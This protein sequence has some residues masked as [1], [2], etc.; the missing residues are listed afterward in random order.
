MLVKNSQVG[1]VLSCVKTLSDGLVKIG[2]KVVVGTCEG[3]GVD[4]MLEKHD[5]KIID[6]STKS[7][8][9]IIG[10][11]CKIAKI[12][13]ENNI[14]IIHAQNRVPAI[15]ASVYC[16]FHSRVKYI[17]SNHLVPISS[18][19]FHRLITRSGE[20]AVAESVVGKRYLLDTFKIPEN[21]LK[22]VNLGSDL[23]KFKKTSKEQQVNLKKRL[24]LDDNKKVILLYG[25]LEPVKGHLFL[26]EAIA[27]LQRERQQELC[28]I[29][30]GENE[31]YKREINVLAQK[32]GLEGILVYPGYINGREYLS[33]ADLMILP[34]KNEGFGIVNIEAFSMK[35][36]VIRTKTA[37]YLD[38]EDCC[39]GMEYGDVDTL[40]MFINYLWD[41]PEIFRET[42]EVA[43]REV[44][45]FSAE[46]M[47]EE[48][49][50]IYRECLMKSKC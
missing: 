33:I 4:K 35:V 24:G 50:K 10:N 13:R 7:P 26:I 42:V 32:Y 1:G 45:R 16:F 46:K 12:V 44:K 9:K 8:V 41:A 40:A 14:D 18:S 5:V 25:R 19:F 37:G 20:F 38:M 17:W 43:Y 48:Y 3:D 28:I 22:V 27:K 49:K 2:D 15:Y 47:T 29:F 21:K 11:Y 23:E 31:S 36:P 30:P 39:L 6:F 34:S